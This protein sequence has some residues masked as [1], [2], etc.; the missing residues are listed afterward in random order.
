MKFSLEQTLK[1][2]LDA[3][4]GELRKDWPKVRA[5]MEQ[6]L[7]RRKQRLKLLVDSHLKGEITQAQFE[8]RLNTVEKM[9]LEAEIHALKVVSKAMAQKAANAAIEVLEKVVRLAVGRRL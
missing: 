8:D 1:D 7:E 9:H 4:Q 2:M 3:M 6:F 5:V